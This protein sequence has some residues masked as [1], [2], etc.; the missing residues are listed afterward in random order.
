VLR[1]LRT[2]IKIRCIPRTL[3]DTSLSSAESFFL[4]GTIWLAGG[5][6][7]FLL[8]PE[9]KGRTLEE[10]EVQTNAQE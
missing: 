9:T 7:V 4:Y 8:V 5:V 2:K 10:I 6:F 1:S 3:L